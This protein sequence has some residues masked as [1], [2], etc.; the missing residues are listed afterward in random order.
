MYLRNLKSERSQNIADLLRAIFHLRD[1]LLNR[2]DL[3]KLIDTDR[4]HLEGDIVRVY[5][6]LVHAG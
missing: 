3:T 5:K 1:E 2:A 4:K 6:L